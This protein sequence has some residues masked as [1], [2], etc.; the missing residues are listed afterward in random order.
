MIYS[1]NFDVPNIY[2]QNL[3]I[4][5]NAYELQS[6]TF[7]E[8]ETVVASNSQRKTKIVC[9]I[10]PSCNTRDMIWKLAEAGMDVA[11]LN[12]SHGDHESHQKIV[13]LVKEYNAQSKDHVIAIM[14]DTKV[15][16]HYLQTSPTSLI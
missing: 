6:G 11:R 4:K 1:A 16:I 9:T 3:N 2:K 15:Y 10:G 7:N 14:L 8:R 13:D 5:L 12:M